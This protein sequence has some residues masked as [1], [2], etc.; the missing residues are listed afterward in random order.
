MPIAHRGDGELAAARD[1]LV[2]ATR[3]LD[4]LRRRARQAATGGGPPADVTDAID[5]CLGDVDRALSAIDELVAD[6]H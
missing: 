6:A 1:T 4:V 3:R 2:A 5:A